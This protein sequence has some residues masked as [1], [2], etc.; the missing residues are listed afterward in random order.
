M[1]FLI[2]FKGLSEAK[3]RWRT[4][5]WKKDELVLEMV[6]QNL[7]TVATVV[8]L[9]NAH[10][11]SPDPRAPELFPEYSHLLVDGCGL[12][13]DLSE[14]RAKLQLG[15]KAMAVL[16]PD[17]PC[18]QGHEVEKL[19]EL[20]RKGQVV[21]C[22][23]QFGVGTNALGLNPSDCLPFL[24]EGESFHRHHQAAQNASLT[25]SILETPGLAQ[26]CDDLE[27]LRKLCL[28]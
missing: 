11:V 3:T 13:Q 10:L 1:K 17:L 22:P 8:G 26:D 28:L 25:I 18:L 2:P 21:I 23:D 27:T 16:L 7:K 20:T 19:V 24:F 4:E 5:S 14:A 15:G 12:N 9:S 6:R